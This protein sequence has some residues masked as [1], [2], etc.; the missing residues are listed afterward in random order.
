MHKWNEKV[1]INHHDHHRV[2][3]NKLCSTQCP[4]SRPPCPCIITT[5]LHEQ[6]KMCAQLRKISLI[7]N[8]L[9]VFT[10]RGVHRAAGPLK[11]SI[12]RW[13]TWEVRSKW[14]GDIYI[15]YIEPLLNTVPT[16]K[17]KMSWSPLKILSLYY[18]LHHII[19]RWEPGWIFRQ[20][21]HSSLSA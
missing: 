3:M 4:L 15:R 13:R 20:L 10:S 18:K 7:Y 5:L 12:L 8:K 14:L 19:S 11:K 16:L 6:T 17:S 1:S 21:P 9:D 2:A